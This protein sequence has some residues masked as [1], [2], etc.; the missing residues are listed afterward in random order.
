MPKILVVGSIAMDLIV[1][2]EVFPSSGETIAG[3]MFQTAPGGKGANQAVQAARL[4][5]DV[6]MVGKVGQD[7]FGDTLLSA[8]EA[9]GVSTAHIAKNPAT[10]TGIANIL[11]E[12]D[13]NGTKNRIIVVPA[14]NMTISYDDIAF[15]EK[16]ITDYDMV[17]LQHEIPSEI[18]KAVCE[19]A[20]KNNVP[21]M[22]NPAPAA[23]IPTEMLAGL[24]YISPNEH[25]AYLLTGVKINIDNGVN[26]DDVKSAAQNLLAKG[27]KNVIITLGSNGASF[28]N[29][30]EFIHLPCIDMGR[31]VDPTA[32]GDS[33]VGA[34]CY[35]VA[36]DMTHSDALTFANKI[37]GITVTR[38]GAQPSLPTIEEL[39]QS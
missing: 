22:L 14:A 10:S 31:V 12:T 11:L 17:I 3:K 4:G 9:S 28:M 34:F 18:N 32:A 15:L 19:I 26:L 6:T 29:G 36:T 25:E 23:D 21:V 37:A 8:L 30:E 27:V 33:F 39:K 13:E 24:A 16:D 5:V 38:M 35:G 2:T 1:E 7:D 20:F